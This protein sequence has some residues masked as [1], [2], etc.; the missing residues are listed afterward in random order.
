MSSF[1]DK[2]RAWDK[3]EPPVQGWGEIVKVVNA[4]EPVSL[5]ECADKIEALEAENARLRAFSL[6]ALTVIEWVA[7]EGF[8]LQHP[9]YDADDLLLEGVDM[10]DVEDTNAA[11]AALAEQEK[12]ND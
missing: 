4:P 7:G 10:L 12:T 2:L 1:L 5:S 8:V 6:K 9:H 11:R 3:W